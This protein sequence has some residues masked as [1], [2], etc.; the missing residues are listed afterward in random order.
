MWVYT[1]FS[2]EIVLYLFW[3]KILHSFVCVLLRMKF[4]IFHRSVLIEFLFYFSRVEVTRRAIICEEHMRGFLLRLAA[5]DE[6]S[7]QSRVEPDTAKRDKRPGREM[8]MNHWRPE[9][10]RRLIVNLGELFWISFTHWPIL[11]LASAP[12]CIA[13]VCVRF[14]KSH[15]DSNYSR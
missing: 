9:P 6:S 10:N 14:S 5:N 3:F 11:I 8:R 4:L 1:N 15:T 2:A 12:T 13:H 7:M